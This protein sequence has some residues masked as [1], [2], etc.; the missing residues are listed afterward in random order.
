MPHEIREQLYAEEAQYVE[1]QRKQGASQAGY[2]PINIT[3]VMPA[4]TPQTSTP[5]SGGLLS[6]DHSAQLGILGL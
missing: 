3:N 6:C 5:E 1:R 2:P 4:Q